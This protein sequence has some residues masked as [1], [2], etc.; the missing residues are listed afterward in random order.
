MICGVQRPCKNLFKTHE[1]S[2]SISKI[3]SKP[4]RIAAK[5]GFAS[6][7]FHK[8]H[9]NKSEYKGIFKKPTAFLSFCSLF[10]LKP[11]HIIANAQKA[12]STPESNFF[13]FEPPA[14]R[15]TSLTRSHSFARTHA[16]THDTNTKRNRNRFPDW[17]Q[18]TLLSPQSPILV[19]GIRVLQ[20][21]SSFFFQ[22]HRHCRCFTMRPPAG[23]AR[24]LLPARPDREWRSE[25]HLGGPPGRKSGNPGILKTGHPEMSDPLIQIHKMIPARTPNNSIF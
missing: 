7:N 9:A 17:A 15:S 21:L 4:I 11:W 8:T 13:P 10:S 20:A 19:F 5:Y 23:P 25:Q 22:R 14:L 18:L 12:H 24:L 1:Y 2:N 6:S 16:R 3:L